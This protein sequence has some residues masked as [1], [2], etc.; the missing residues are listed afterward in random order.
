MEYTFSDLIDTERIQALSDSFYEVTGIPSSLIDLNGTILSMSGWRDICTN[1]HRVN[2]QT[3]SKCKEYHTSQTKQLEKY[4]VNKCPLGL[5][6]TSS[7]IVI[8]G[9]H[10]ANMF[11]SQFFLEKPDTEYFRKQAHEFGIDETSYLGALS[12]VPG[13]TEEKIE[14]VLITLFNFAKILVEMGL[15]KLRQFESTEKLRESEGRF[16]SLSETTS[17]LVWEVDEKSMYTYVSPKIRDILGY[18]PEEI[19]GKTLF[20]LMP[21]EEARYV[22]DIFDEIV[23]SK[24]PFAFLEKTNLHKDGYL[25]VLESSGVPF[26]D[27]DGTFRGYRG[28]DR[29]ITE[30]RKAKEALKESEARYR[31][32]FESSTDG[33]LI[34]DS[35][36]RRFKYANPA[37]CKMLG[38]SERELKG[39]GV[40]DI[41][42]KESLE[43]VISEFEA[44]ARKEKTLSLNIPCLR[45]D[46]TVIYADI[47]IGTTL[48]NDKKCIIGFFRDITERKKIEEKLKSSLGE[49]E[50][51]LQEIH[52]RVKNNMQVITSMLSLQSAQIEDESINAVFRDS[53]NRIK[54]MA[55]IHETLHQSPS[56]SEIDFSEYIKKLVNNVHYVSRASGNRP[57]LT[58]DAED[59]PLNIDQAIPC[60]LI[61]NELVTNSFKHAFPDGRQGKVNISLHPTGKD[62]VELTI[63]DN[64]TGIPEDID[65]KTINTLGLR[66]V[67][68]L[69]EDQLKGKLELN[70]NEGTEF[71]ICFNVKN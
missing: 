12:R 50:L 46:G 34:A 19:M 11:I 6:N 21:P 51:L 36:G 42:P 68:S 30:P 64:G 27:P 69:T 56:L 60:G 37:L 71:K 48:I 22:S 18:E 7:P 62:S 41:H 13:I 24:K 52:H 44:Q 10:V 39:M 14:L 49:K 61:I 32:L 53:Q 55:L 38:Y 3:L 67:R 29:D 4:S 57:L 16:R 25:V 58:I 43:Y 66:L 9:E 8:E 47:N 1:F 63:S 31:T 35:E 65:L 5:I 26:F 40:D 20:D 45:K 59:L 54:V 17:D 23:A 15:E 28:I 70:R 2:H 33:I